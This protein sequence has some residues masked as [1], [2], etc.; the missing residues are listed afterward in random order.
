MYGRGEELQAASVAA[1]INDLGV[2]RALNLAKQNFRGLPLAVLSEDDL[3]SSADTGLFEKSAHAALGELDAFVSHAWR[4]PA[5]PK[6]AAL[7]AWGRSFEEANGRA[8]IVWLDKACVNQS[9]IQEALAC[10][11]VWLA[12]CES[13]LVLAS[14]SYASRL[15]CVIELHTWCVMGGDLARV[16]VLPV[17]PAA[18]LHASFA[19]FRVENAD[20]FVADD[21]ARLLAVI[22]S[23]FG[24]HD[25]FS[26]LIRDLMRSRL[27]GK[28]S[29]A[30][31]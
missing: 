23:G 9:R 10:L 12:G 16:S 18:E 13:L 22:E 4:D 30:K 25:A 28:G 8:P 15:W 14:S 29:E 2:T 27:P 11:P 7:V 21:K 5:P 19:R 6:F 26:A 3:R 31:V 24:T 20:C 1:L 17:A